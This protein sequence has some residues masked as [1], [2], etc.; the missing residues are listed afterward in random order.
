MRYKIIEVIKTSERES[1]SIYENDDLN[2]ALATL[3]YD[4]GTAVKLDTTV[5]VYVLAIDSNDGFVVAKQY[6]QKDDD[7]LVSTDTAF[8]NR[9]FTT[10][11][12]EADNLAPYDTERL[13]IGNYH[14]KIARAMNLAECNKAITIRIDGAGNAVDSDMFVRNPE[15]ENPEE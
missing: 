13:A 5:A 8:R 3:H 15:T 1:Q 7:T 11:D 10:N 12:F 2:A 9:V 6:W 14:T 4:F